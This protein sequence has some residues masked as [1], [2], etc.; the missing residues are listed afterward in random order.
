MVAIDSAR[1]QPWLRVLSLGTSEAVLYSSDGCEMVARCH[2]NADGRAGGPA[3]GNS[4]RLL[5]RHRLIQINV[6]VHDRQGQLITDLREDSPSSSAVR[7]S[8]S[9]SSDG[10]R[11]RRAGA[12]SHIS[13]G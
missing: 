3:T 2:R 6:V 11:E 4:A 10:R 12:G 7:R 9:R 13:A 8:R 5:Y 1:A